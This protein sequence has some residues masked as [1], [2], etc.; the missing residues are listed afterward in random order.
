MPISEVEQQFKRIR[1]LSSSSVED[2]FIYFERQW[3]NGTI[4]LS[5]W[6]ANET[7]HRTNNTSEG[8]RKSILGQMNLFFCPFPILAYNRRFG[9]R[10]IQKHPNVWTFIRLIQDEHVRFEHIIIQLASGATSLKQSAKTT[11]YQRRF[12][13]LN[14]RFKNGEI[15]SKQLLTG[16]TLLV[17]RPRK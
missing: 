9:T 16:L 8:I 7:I 3:I 10:L 2:L 11:A 14:T 17:G 5:L 13:T 12:E 15:T 1:A 6:N 4:P